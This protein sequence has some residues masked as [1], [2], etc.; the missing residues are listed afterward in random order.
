MEHY[1]LLTVGLLILVCFQWLGCGDTPDDMMEPVEEETLNPVETL[2]LEPILPKLSVEE[3][4][5]ELRKSF[6]NRIL[7]REFSKL[8]ELTASETYLRFLSQE[9]PAEK[10]FETFDAFL[11]TAEPDS[12]RYTPFLM[13]FIEHP[14][15]KDVAIIH[16]MT[17]VYRSANVIQWH[18]F[19]GRNAG[20]GMDEVLRRKVSVV[21]EPEVK[22]WL[23]A[24]FDNPNQDPKVPGQVFF[25]PFEEFVLETEKADALRI[26]ELFAEHGTDAGLIWLAILEPA[27]T[28]QILNGFTDTDF[29]LIWVEGNFFPKG[30][31]FPAL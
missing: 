10:P 21:D 31:L 7:N 11:E 23:K 19:H 2:T 29:F 25:M 6:P 4:F 18:V 3:T 13:E 14:T 16:H 20:A 1:R 5:T 28:G 26:K 12:G 27:L 15:A 30:N 17:R 8:R 22:A 9:Y 24:H